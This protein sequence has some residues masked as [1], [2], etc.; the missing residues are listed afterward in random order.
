MTPGTMVHHN[1]LHNY[2]SINNNKHNKSCCV[3]YCNISGNET[4]CTGTPH[5]S[6]RYQRTASGNNIM[7]PPLCFN[8]LCHVSSCSLIHFALE[9]HS[10]IEKGRRLVNKK[11]FELWNEEYRDGIKT[12]GDKIGMTLCIIKPFK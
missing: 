7:R 5:R 12:R 10:V 2:K 1:H 11:F 4:W 6:Y 9:A 3:N 8:R